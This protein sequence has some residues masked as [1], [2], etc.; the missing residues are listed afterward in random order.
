M[1]NLFD[2]YW[3]HSSLSVLAIG[4][5]IIWCIF[6]RVFCDVP[7]STCTSFLGFTPSMVEIAVGIGVALIVQ[8]HTRKIQKKEDNEIDLTIQ[9]TY[10]NLW[11]IHQSLN[12]Y[13]LSSDVR[14]ENNTAIHILNQLNHTQSVLSK[15]S[16]KIKQSIIKDLQ[17]HL[18]LIQSTVSVSLDPRADTEEYWLKNKDSV[19]I[20][21]QQLEDISKEHFEP[22]IPD[23]QKI[24]W[25]IRK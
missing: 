8:N 9:N 6:N 16:K 23:S 22:L 17:L 19:Q 10:Y 11:S 3:L 20:S 13:I 5:L 2:K 4:A 18:V 24:T 21:F 25:K 14:K 12:A 7:S 15:C 1:W